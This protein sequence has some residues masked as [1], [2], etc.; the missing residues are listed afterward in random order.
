MPLAEQLKP[1]YPFDDEVIAGIEAAAAWQNTKTYKELADFYDIG[2]GPHVFRPTEHSR[3]IEMVHFTPTG[4]YDEKRARVLRVPMGHGTDTNMIMRAMRFFAADPSEQLFVFGNPTIAGN[5]AGTVSVR[6]AAKVLWKNTLEPFVEPSLQYLASKEVAVESTNELGYSLAAD[7]GA[8]A[9]AHAARFGIAVD[10]GVFVGSAAGA[11]W[12]PF[13]L[14]AGFYATGKE[15]DE[16]RA[17]A[18]CPPY[19]EAYAYENDEWLRLYGRGLARLSNAVIFATLARGG[20]YDRV[21]AG[22]EAQPA[23]HTV[24]GWGSLDEISI[25][26]VNI[27]ETAKLQEKYGS[28]VAAMR[29]DG[30]HHAGADN[31]NFHAAFMLQG[32]RF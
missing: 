4:D 31:I 22:L 26:A 1:Y 12:N 14:G 19:N 18:A 23:M 6:Q 21:D 20:F 7:M 32:Q 3:P 17:D 9:S 5:S 30:V 11:R 27:R 8:T 25:D 10:H 16:Y 15:L 24:V 29:L 13:K 2:D 28:R